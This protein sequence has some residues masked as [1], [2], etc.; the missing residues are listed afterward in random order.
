MRGRTTFVIAHRLSTIRSADQIVVIDRGQVVERG[1]HKGLIE[2]GGVYRELHDLHGASGSSAGSDYRAN[3][4]AGNQPPELL[5]QTEPALER[6][7]IEWAV[8]MSRC[9]LRVR[10]MDADIAND[11]HETGLIR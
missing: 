9:G 7:A 1:T 3:G 5:V 2:V 8:G 4:S 11:S 10:C 6:E